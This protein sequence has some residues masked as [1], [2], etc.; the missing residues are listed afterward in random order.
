MRLRIVFSLM[1][2]LG[3]PIAMAD[4]KEPRTMNEWG[5]CSK[6]SK[7]KEP[8]SNFSHCN[9]PSTTR[10]WE[11]CSRAG[12][13]K[14][15]TNNLSHCENPRTTDEW[16]KCSKVAKL[17]SDSGFPFSRKNRTE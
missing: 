13:F 16:L 10:E 4:C 5:A 6:S 12:K 11:A 7:F 8:E 1:C 14:E 17:N 9:R 2:L 3:S 15:P